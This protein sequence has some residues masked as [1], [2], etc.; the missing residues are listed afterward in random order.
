M[1]FATLQGL[2][3]PE[4]VVTQITDAAGRVLWALSGGKVILEVEKIIHNTYAGETTYENEEFI[5]LDIYPKTNGTV[6]VTYGGLTKTITDTSGA[7]E[8]NAQQVYFGTLYGVSDSVTTPASGKLTIEGE[9]RGFGI[10][11]CT[12]A[13]IGS[14]YYVPC[15]TAINN[16]GNVEIIPAYAFGASVGGT[17][18]K[19]VSVKIPESVESIGTGAF[20]GCGGLVNVTLSQNITDIADSLFFMC[21]ALESI[22]IPSNVRSIGKAFLGCPGLTSVI[23]ENESGWYVTE[24]LDA[25]SGIEVDV[26]DPANNAT[27]LKDTY[28]NYYWYRS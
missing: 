4:G 17:C 6:T 12:T 20:Y 1:N 21:G 11:P 15:I 8:P 19:I 7:A 16:F 25:T 13:K 9:C 2:T 23:F 26:S 24:T 5:L 14:P 3:I 18:E 10:G 28:V 27:L 22:I